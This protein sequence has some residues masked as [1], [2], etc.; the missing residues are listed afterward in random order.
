MLANVAGVNAERVSADAA[1]T[2]V[3]RLREMSADLRGCA[4][5]GAE[6]RVLAATGDPDRWGAAASDLLAAADEAGDEPA[7]HVHVATEDGET[8]AVREG[9]LAMVAV[10]ERFTLAS[11]M[12]FDMR[13]VLRD[14][15]REE[16]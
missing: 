7:S 11:L 15:A 13:A 2:A 6:G 10:T 16:G 12:I 4:V 1:E 5:L 3:D 14:L 8:F 9:G